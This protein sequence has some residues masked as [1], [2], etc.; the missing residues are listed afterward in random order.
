M[1][2]KTAS[3]P[4]K[5]HFIPVHWTSH[6][7]QKYQALSLPIPQ[8][9]PEY[10]N[11]WRGVTVLNAPPR[12]FTE[13]KCLRY[14]ALSLVVNHSLFRTS[15]TQRGPGN[16]VIPRS[17]KVSGISSPVKVSHWQW[18]VSG[19]SSTGQWTVSGLSS[20]GQWTVSGLSSLGQWKVSG[21]SSL[22][23]WTVSGLSSLGQWT[24][25]GL[26]SPGQ[27]QGSL[28]LVSFRA[29]WPRSVSEL[30]AWDSGQFQGCLDQDSGRFQGCLAWD[31]GKFQGC[32]AWDSGKFQGCLAW[33]SGQFQGCLS[34]D[35]GQFQGCLARDSGQF[36]GC[37]AQDNG[38]FQGSGQFQ[39][40]L[41][42]GSG[43]FQG[44]LAWESGQFQ[45]WTVS[46]MSSPVQWP[47]P[48]TEAAAPPQVS[49]HQHARRTPRNPSESSACNRQPDKVFLIHSLLSRQN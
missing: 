9:V 3:R 31:S 37:L 41:A 48:S 42:Q 22:G 17:W 38:Q 32:L 7:C 10:F 46:G 47:V 29:V 26:S 34:W 40:C 19:L 45:D 25:S 36:Q 4:G 1:T 30:H 2:T 15:E 39:G 27:F 11:K 44:C 14:L 18:T 12:P 43:Q 49:P 35:S 24:V 16:S 5:L 23:Q 20:P 13:L 33:D 21:L 28:A 6:F 8:T